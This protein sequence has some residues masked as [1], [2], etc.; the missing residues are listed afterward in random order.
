[1][2]W[3]N[4]GV[5]VVLIYTAKTG[6]EEGLVIGA[7]EV[8][9]LFW[10]IL[11]AFTFLGPLSDMLQR[12][13]VPSQWQAQIIGFWLPFLV[14]AIGLWKMFGKK[15][16]KE[17][18]VLFHHLDR[19]GGLI[20][21]LVFGL[22]LSSFLVLTVYMIPLEGEAFA[23]LERPVLFRIDELLPRFYG[24]VAKEELLWP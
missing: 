7:V 13:L 9:I 20:F 12:F 18:I 17:K 19:W 4:L 5:I 24:L 3:L 22:A 23:F 21:G 1:M 6:F 14:V 8:F 2:N 15:L 11:A 10:A 16:Q